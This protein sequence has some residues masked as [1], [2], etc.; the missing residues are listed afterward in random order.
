MVFLRSPFHPLVWCDRHPRRTLLGSMNLFQAQGVSD[1]GQEFMKT[2]PEAARRMR[3][4]VSEH[5]HG[6]EV[7]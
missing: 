6:I 7:G 5:D 1:A 2:G 4:R 3:V